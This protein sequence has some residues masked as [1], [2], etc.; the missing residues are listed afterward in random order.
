[1]FHVSFTV[2]EKSVSYK[3][4]QTRILISKSRGWKIWNN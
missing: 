4:R 1:M 3:K 2:S